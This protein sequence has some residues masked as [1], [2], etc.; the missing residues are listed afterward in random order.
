MSKFI[1]EAT[2]TETNSGYTGYTGGPNPNGTFTYLQSRV[3]VEA[4]DV[5]AA[6]RAVKNILY[7]PPDSVGRNGVSKTTYKLHIT[8]SEIEIAPVTRRPQRVTGEHGVGDMYVYLTGLEVPVAR[9]EEKTVLLDY[10]ANGD[11]IGIEIL[12]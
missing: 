10:D 7:M 1:G 6:E 9:T 8:W 5:D 4:S 2:I 11:I 12:R 3:S